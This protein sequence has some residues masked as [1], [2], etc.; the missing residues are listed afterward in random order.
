MKIYFL[1]WELG[2][3]RYDVCCDKQDFDGVLSDL[4]EEFIITRKDPSGSSCITRYYITNYY[5][6]LQEVGYIVDMDIN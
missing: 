4:E 6:E 5:G 3:H 2:A 1:K